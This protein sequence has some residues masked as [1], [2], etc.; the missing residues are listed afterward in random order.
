VR[1]TPQLQVED[2]GVPQSVSM[3]LDSGIRLVH[4]T[5]IPETLAFLA[6][7]VVD[8]TNRGFSVIAI[9]SPGRALGFFGE[10]ERIPTFGV[11][12]PRRVTP[13]RDLLAVGRIYRHFRRIRP[14]I[15]H[16][17]TPKGGLLAMIG[18]WLARVPVRIY[19]IHGLPYMTKTGSRRALLRC[20]ERVACALAHQVLCVSHSI[21]EVAVTEGLC[22]ANKVTVLRSGTVNGVDAMGRFDPARF[23]G[24]REQ[25]R[26][27]CGIPSSA[28]VLGF[29]G[30]IVRDKGLVELIQSWKE[31]REEFP[32]LHL[33]V[34]GPFESQD[35]LPATV[36][37]MLHA[38]PRIHLMGTQPDPAPLYGAMDLVILP[39]YREGF[40]TVPLEA[41]AMALP[42]VATRVPGCID[43]VE[44]GVTG[45]LVPARDPQAL[46]DAIR[47]YLSNADLRRR[48]GDAGRDRVLRD[49]RREPIWEALYQEYVWLL[50]QR[51]LALSPPSSRGSSLATA[52]LHEEVG[53]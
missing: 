1:R 42:V 49:F 48:H 33:L 41:A 9:S 52:C 31:L 7:Q 8:M 26:N 20:T 11:A 23:T 15:V 3:R 30:R 17:H 35:P 27:R 34:V 18:A 21:R 53:S 36:V 29:V 4:V 10:R 38:D 22:T 12:M 14:H 5:T 6:G 44:D 40:P 39:T 2:A 24:M 13:L 50:R 16:A 32:N 51:G 43:A 46:A 45:K 19:H 37:N 25:T 28:M 47:I